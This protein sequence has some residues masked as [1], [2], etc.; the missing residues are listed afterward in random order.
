[1]YANVYVIYDYCICMAWHGWSPFEM[2]TECVNM[3]QSLWVRWFL[4]QAR[5]ERQMQDYFGQDPL[6]ASWGAAGRS[7]KGRGCD[8]R[9]G[10]GVSINGARKWMVYNLDNPTLTIII[11]LQNMDL[12]VPPFQETSR[13]RQLRTIGWLVPTPWAGR[14]VE[15]RPGRWFNGIPGVIKMAGK[16]L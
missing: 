5:W 9:Q 15:L 6:G 11:L 13:W 3:C 1:M 14:S 8:G 4:H 16:S 7:E 12:A 10:T 2:S